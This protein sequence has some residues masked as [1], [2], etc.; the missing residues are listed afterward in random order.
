VTCRA[1]RVARWALTLALLSGSAAIAQSPRDWPSEGP[2]RPLPARQVNFPPYEIRTLANGMQIVTV[3][4][5]EQPAVS[6]RLVVRAGAAQDP[7]GKGGVATLT[8][9]LLDQ[10]TTTKSAFQI[11]DTIDFIGGGLGTGA[12]SD[13]SVVNVV[14]MKD[15]FGLAMDLLADVIRNPAFADEEIERQ[16]QQ[17]VSSLQVSAG[18]PDYLASVVFDRLVYGFH[19]YGL[20]NSGTAESLASITRADLQAFHK[21]FFVPNNMIVAIVGDV[22]ADE[23]FGAADRVFGKWERADVPVVRTDDPPQPTRRVVVIDKPDAVQTEI[24][25]GHIGIPRKHPD[26]MA[27]DLAFKILGGEGANRLHRVLRSERGLTYGASA[28]IKTLKQT[29]DFMAETDTR[30]ETTGEALRLIFDEYAKLRRERVNEREL[31]DAQAYLAGH[32]PLTIETP[33]AIATQVLNAVFY[34]LPLEEVPTYRER[35]QA[36]TPDDVQRVARTFISPERL[37]V[38]LV[39]NAAGFVGQLKGLG[40]AEF[41]VIP[42]GEV[43]LMAASLRREPRRAQVLEF[44]GGSGRNE[45]TDLPLNYAP[46]AAQAAQTSSPDPAR[47]RELA[48]RVVQAKGGLAKLKSIRTVV[49]EAKTTLRM[50]QGPLESMTK[51]YV[52]YPDKFRVDAVVGGANVVQ[53][54]NAGDAWMTDPNGTREAPAPMKAEFAASVQRDMIPLLVAAAEGKLTASVLPDEGRDGRTLRVLEIS[55]E[56]LTPVRLYVDA[57]GLIVRQTFSRPGADG[58]ETQAE[59]AFSDYRDVDGVKVPFTAELMHSGRPVLTRA[60]TDVKFNT[61][62]DPKLFSRP[63]P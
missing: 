42:I 4:H 37:S 26:Y 29:G 30:T 15:S 24:R 54:Y 49:A 58:R 22:T 17:L 32:F 47:G 23:A 13:H 41:E 56:G 62:V 21:R 6:V 39:G 43:D 51:T 10:G 59:E 52:V 18:D 20:P 25:V 34:D 11:A 50:Q 28:D 14:V 5:H 45:L 2:P 55:G 63:A 19:P 12:L 60:L 53:V 9:A 46:V 1:S 16:R 48:S 44:R 57:A 38:V 8:A 35:V 27:V 31:A 33:D 3:L 36:V 7:K 61:P 40:F